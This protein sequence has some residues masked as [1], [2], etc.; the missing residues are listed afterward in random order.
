MISLSLYALHEKSASH[1]LEVFPK[2]KSGEFKQC[3]DVTITS[4]PYW[5]L[6]NYGFQD[7]IGYGQTYDQYLNDLENIFNHV[8]KVTKP[9]GSLWVI[10]D[11]FKKKGKDYSLDG[12]KEGELVPLPFDVTRR[13]RRAGWKLQDTIIWMKDKTLPWSRKGQ[14]RNIFEYIFFFSKTDH[15]KFYVDRIRISDNQKLQKWWVKYPERYNPKGA[16]PTDIWKYPIPVQGSWASGYLRHFCPFPVQMVERILHLTTNQR[17][18]VL[19]PFAGSGVVLAV[20][21]VMKRHYIGFELNSDYL[22]MFRERVLIEIQKEALYYEKR[23]QEKQRERNKLRRTIYKLRLTKY[24]KT[25]T[26]QL[27]RYRY[28]E[29]QAPLINTI[30]AIERKPTDRQSFGPWKLLK[31]D[32]YFIFDSN[33]VK[34]LQTQMFKIASKPP[35]SKFG[36]KADIHIF[37]KDTFIEKEIQLPSFDHE[38]LWLYQKG[39]MNFYHMQLSFKTWKKLSNQ[40]KWSSFFKNGIPPIVSNIK[41]RQEVP[42]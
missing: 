22:R 17:N 21:K 41:V 27:Y 13:I 19:D 24:P 2:L 20:A 9:T 33:I 34:K 10:L 25:L 38:N 16:V 18:V 23:R 26:K 39:N 8:Y 36:I 6:K 42:S 12:F 15:Y 5:N 31:E 40:E 28:L 37:S 30:F 29:K 4:P 1:L 11:T 32:V 3:V 35:L 14:V 7:Q